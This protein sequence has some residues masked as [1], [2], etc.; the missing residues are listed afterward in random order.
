M[1]DKVLYSPSERVD[2]PDM[3]RSSNGY[4]SEMV[5]YHM[6]RVVTGDRGYVLDGFRVQ[7]INGVG[8]ASV[9]IYNGNAVAPDG[10]ILN[11]EAN[12]SYSV[13]IPL[14]GANVTFYLELEF[15]ED[16]T[17]EDSRAFWDATVPN[18]PPIPNGQEYVDT[19]PTRLSPTWRV[20]TPVSTTGFSWSLTNPSSL[21]VPLMRLRTDA[22]NNVTV[23]ENPGLA[24][25][26]PASVLVQDYLGASTQLVV[27]D[28]RLF[29]EISGSEQITIDPDNVTP[30]G[31]VIVNVAAVD[32]VNNI[33][34]LSAPTS[35]YPPGT[36]VRATGVGPVLIAERTD[37][38]VPV[39]PSTHP[40][41]MRR[42]WQGDESRGTGLMVSKEDAATRDDLNL[43]DLKGYVDFLAGQLH[44]V[45]WG[46]T[47]VGDDETQASRV[48]PRTWDLVNNPPRYHSKTR[49]IQ[50]A[51]AYAITIGDGVSSYGDFNGTDADVFQAAI[52]AAN[53][54]DTIFVK[55]GT[56]TLTSTV[57]ITK[58]LTFIGDGASSYI[59]S[60]EATGLFLVTTA[61]TLTFR[62]LRLENTS[63]LLE[64][65]VLFDA[66]S[67]NDSCIIESCTINGS[68][69]Y[70]G[71]TP[72]VNTLRMSDCIVT[73]S[74]TSP[75][76][77]F[78]AY[79]TGVSLSAFRVEVVRCKFTT[80][81][82]QT[83]LLKLNAVSRL[84][85]KDNEWLCTDTS[86]SG[87]A[88]SLAIDLVAAN[89]VEISNHMTICSGTHAARLFSATGLVTSGFIENVTLTNGPTRYSAT[90][91]LDS[92]INIANFSSFN[93]RGVYTALISSF[94]TNGLYV[95]MQLGQG[96]TGTA[97]TPKLTISEC[98]GLFHPTNNG[99]FVNVGDGFTTSTPTLVT[100]RDCIIEN[101]F[102][103]IVAASDGDLNVDNCYISGGTSSNSGIGILAGN[104]T[105][106]SKLDVNITNTVIQDLQHPTVAEAVGVWI[107]SP[108]GTAVTAKTNLHMDGCFIE[109]VG[110]S[111]S[112]ALVQ[113]S[114]V[115]CEETSSMDRITVHN[116]SIRTVG[117]PGGGQAYG[118]GIFATLEDVDVPAYGGIKVTNNYIQGIGTLTNYAFG[119]GVSR[120]AAGI[121]P[122]NNLH[123]SDN[124]I[125]VESTSIANYGILCRTFSVM[126]RA[127][128]TDNI[129]RV[130][131]ASSLFGSG[132]Q[133]EAADME[134]VKI[135]GTYFFGGDVAGPGVGIAVV[136]NNATNGGIFTDINVC[137]NYILGGDGTFTTFGTLYGILFF[138]V[139]GVGPGEFTEWDYAH[140]SGNYIV[141]YHGASTAA[142]YPQ[143]NLIGY[144][145][146]LHVDNNTTVSNQV[147]PAIHHI[148]INGVDS[149]ECSRVTIS[150]N[151]CVGPNASVVYT[152][153]AIKLN[154]VSLFTITGNV[155]DLF[156]SSIVPGTGAV[157]HCE[158][159]CTGGTIVGNIL[160]GSLANT[161]ILFSGSCTRILAVGNNFAGVTGVISGAV[162]AN[163]VVFNA[164]IGTAV[165]GVGPLNLTS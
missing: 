6:Q 105:T 45:K 89:L 19:V 140:V 102:A 90:S 127:R 131:Q 126:N 143:I 92:A 4:T 57:D 165:D 163:G 134:G 91:G 132:V 73:G 115:R 147:N 100:V 12:P 53:E 93:I 71:L 142:P 69:I 28:A 3:L 145:H 26:N 101:A 21:R 23:A 149:A 113:A 159:A 44:E 63:P 1:P 50:G 103:A 5:G 164:G 114:G 10:V 31:T 112:A 30:S 27:A 55:A 161:D 7:V 15:V 58:S 75:Q 46:S 104:V 39:D 110:Y 60:A 137:K 121:E 86:G 157:L 37:G 95:F 25:V 106:A 42:M 17:A 51:G 24:L 99:L 38:A 135:E 61:P 109:N 151:T 120:G 138:G 154:E 155:V 65:C 35:P 76:S 139:A 124:T 118:I 136:S 72:S 32:R 156:S 153:A 47:L 129:I 116:S 79:Y 59:T 49:G 160:R 29:S 68:V 78:G 152:D 144:F 148:W 81:G 16:A 33:V 40:D 85:W 146:D 98:T 34:T 162:P 43:R 94:S 125:D 66:L 11:N 2:I 96:N 158:G 54:G 41:N 97:N 36:V 111:G 22:S 108:I 84:T 123:I 14:V 8:T 52:A 64:W 77:M 122:L 119:V 18:V 62:N 83:K 74:A 67:T 128:I 20:V 107:L 48:P 56:Y 130:S 82:N 9:E 70:D 133:V 87:V 117:C 80:T 88:G 13:P 141:N 150:N